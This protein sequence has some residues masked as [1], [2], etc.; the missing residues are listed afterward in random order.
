MAGGNYS[1]LCWLMGAV[2][3]RVLRQASRKRSRRD[4]GYYYYSVGMGGVGWVDVWWWW[5]WLQV[6]KCPI[7]ITTIH[8]YCTARG[9]LGL[10][11]DTTDED[12]L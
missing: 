11:Q 1:D 2:V 12:R 9:P 8:Y 5:W 10:L 6:R 4:S 3:A 7:A